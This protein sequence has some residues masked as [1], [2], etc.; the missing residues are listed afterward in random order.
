VLVV[1]AAQHRLG[2]HT[3]FLQ[4]SLES[5]V[6]IQR[7]MKKYGKITSKSSI[8]V[9]APIISNKYLVRLLPLS[10]SD[11]HTHKYRHI[12]PYRVRTVMEN[13]ENTWNFKMVV[14]RPGEVMEKT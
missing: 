2:H 1:V 3:T 4:K 5:T 6:K 13:L 9:H 8:H 14:S 7:G 11:T 12:Y 10:N